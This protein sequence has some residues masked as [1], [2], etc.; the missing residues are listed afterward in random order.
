M[1]AHLGLPEIF[2][3]L[4]CLVGGGMGV[5]ALLDPA[6]TVGLVRLVPDPDQHEGRSELR[7]IYGGLFT[8]GHGFALAAVLLAPAGA[9]AAAAVAAGWLGAG[10]V[11]FAFMRAD[12]GATTYNVLGGGFEVVMGAA[13]IAPLAL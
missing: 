2:A 6:W 13:L 5:K 12:K 7:A 8:G 10:A 9:W 3:V 11:R 4:A 1:P